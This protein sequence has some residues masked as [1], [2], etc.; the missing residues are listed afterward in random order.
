MNR[1]IL[2]ESDRIDGHRFRLADHRAVHI[3]DILMA[4]LG[5]TL[6]V[7]LLNGP[8]GAARITLVDQSCV[9]FVCEFSN[10]IPA[11]HP[12]VDILCAVP[13]PKSLRKVLHTAAMMGVRRMMFVRANRT[14]KNYLQSPLL[15]PV[16]WTPYLLDGLAQ[17]GLT[18]L[19]E[20]SVHPLFRPCVE[21]EIP[22][23]VAASRPDILLVPEPDAGP[24][25]REACGACDQSHI[26]VAIGPEGGWVPFELDLLEAQ[27]FVRCRLG[28][29]TLRVESAMVA[30]L[31][32]IW[33]SGQL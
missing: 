24:T 20:I 7:G 25:V 5:D 32:Q 30:M 15:S 13:R 16:G 19:P 11:I 14:D 2:L 31:A 6:R 26:L 4:Q 21:D 8:I 29:W 3:R 23:V 28:P 27:G 12:S 18:R 1:I 22:A 9:E 33:Q 10:T 17:G